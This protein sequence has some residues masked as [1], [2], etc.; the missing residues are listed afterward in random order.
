MWVPAKDLTTN[1]YVGMCINTH[2]VIP[3]FSV[4][5]TINQHKTEEIKLLLDKPEYWFMMGYF[6]GDGWIEHTTKNDDWCKYLI[7]FAISNRDE[8]EVFEKINQTLK[9]VD[10]HCD[11]EKC[12]K[13]GCSSILWHSILQKFGCYTHGKLI[14]EW[15]QNAPKH[16][17]QEFINGYM[18][19]DGN[20][21]SDE[22]HHITTVSYNLAMGLQRLYLKLGHISSV[23]KSICPNHT[24]IDGRLVNQRNTYTVEVRLTLKENI[25]SLIEY[26]YVWRKIFSVDQ[27]IH[28]NITVHN[29]EVDQDHSYIVANMIVHNCQGVSIAGYRNSNDP[30][31]S[32]FMEFVRYLQFYRS[33]AFIMENVIGILS[34]KTNTGEKVIDIIMSYF[35]QDYNC[36]ICKLFAS[37]F[38]VPQNRRRTIIIGI[39]KDLTIL[40]TEPQKSQETMLQSKMCSYLKSKSI[41][42]II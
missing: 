25:S 37:D 4:N 20:I 24:I 19:T 6:V 41:H 34:M 22:S 5:T 38:E 15:V 30:R 3:V 9:I 18:K 35:Q 28:N 29:F 23:S 31:N 42:H 21:K 33:K 8:A 1:D 11:T 2:N 27:K 17:I 39:R 13:F 26:N 32:L 40:P 10:Q 16:L 12:K 7:G 14:P 36:I